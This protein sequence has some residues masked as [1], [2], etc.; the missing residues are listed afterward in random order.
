[1]PLTGATLHRV[2]AGVRRAAITQEGWNK[3]IRSQKSEMEAGL[4]DFHANGFERTGIPGTTNFMVLDQG[5][6]T[7]TARESSFADA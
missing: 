5:P 6:S 1:M 4:P 2:L 7:A 3:H